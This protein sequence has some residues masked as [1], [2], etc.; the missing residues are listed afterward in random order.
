M[1]TMERAR[2]RGVR[3]STALLREVAEELRDARRT[4]GVSQGHVA[5]VAGLTQSAVSRVERGVRRRAT[6]EDLAVHAA[7]LGLRLSVKLYPAGSA[8]RDAAQLGVVAALRSV[9]HREFTW[10]SEAPVAGHGDLRAWDVRLS[11]PFTAGLDIESR[12]HDVQ[13]LQRRM[14]LKRRDGDVERVMLVV[15]D[16]RHNRRVL[17]EHAVDL[18]TTFPGRPKVMLR[19]LIDGVDPG[20]DGLVVLAARQPHTAGARGPTMSPGTRQAPSQI[21]R[22]PNESRRRSL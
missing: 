7:A 18:A 11:G 21:L 14:Q 15:A 6:V 2:D 4:A 19:A 5:R 9:I 10:Q 8:V 12:L 1:P 22:P 13:A 20:I 17:A 3:V 16:T